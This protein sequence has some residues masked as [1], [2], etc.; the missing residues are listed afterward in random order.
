MQ[1][2]IRVGRFIYGLALLSIGVVHFAFGHSPSGLIPMG[3]GWVF[4]L[5]GALLVITGAVIAAGAFGGSVRAANWAAFTAAGFFALIYC[6]IGLPLEIMHPRDPA[7]WTGPAELLCLCAGALLMARAA[8]AAP[9]WVSISR[10]ILAACLVV[11]GVQHFLYDDYCASVIPTWIPWPYFWTYFVAIAY[12]ATSI[13]LIL[14]V[15]VRLSALLASIMFFTW[16]VILHEPLVASHVHVEPQWTSG[17]NCLAMG[18]IF[19]TLYALSPRVKPWV[20][21][22]ATQQLA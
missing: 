2:I 1:P 18:A 7:G 20:S 5:D 12:F 4:Y 19:L 13:S 6:C 21:K 3:E 15:L 14:N 11:F 10:Y 17:L 8:G 9:R 16:V 22:P